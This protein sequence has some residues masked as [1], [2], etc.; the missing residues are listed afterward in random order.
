MPNRQVRPTI[1][2]RYSSDSQN[3]LSARDQI[4]FCKELAKR[5]GWRVVE[6]Y[7]DAAMSGSDSHRPDL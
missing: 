4:A 7:S 6:A 2:A 1:F 5:Q 3:P